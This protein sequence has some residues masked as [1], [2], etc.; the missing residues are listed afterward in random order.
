MNAAHSRIQ[1]LI[2]GNPRSHPDFIEQYFPLANGK[3]A[4]PVD[5]Q[6]RNDRIMLDFLAAYYDLNRAHSKL[7][8][9]RRNANSST[10][11]EAERKYLPEVDKL[12]VARDE[13]E[14]HYAPCG[15]FAQPV[16]KDGFTVNIKFSFGNVDSRGRARGDFFRLTADIPLPL[17]PGANL[18]DYIVSFQG[19]EP[20]ISP[21][22]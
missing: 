10:P 18:T 9:I 11:S 1:P 6:E 15:V 12:L 2:L 17:P 3:P 21:T 16:S 22:E 7:L 20:F 13:V 14:N 5:S 4:P 19:P 8:E